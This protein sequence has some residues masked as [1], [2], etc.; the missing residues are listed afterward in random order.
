MR[1][2][3]SVIFR[4]RESKPRRFTVALKKLEK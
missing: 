3:A 1:S 4:D 2:A